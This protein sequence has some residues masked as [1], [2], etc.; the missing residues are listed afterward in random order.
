M[1][2]F[3]FLTILFLP[4]LFI[5][6]SEP[7]FWLFFV[8]GRGKWLHLVCVTLLLWTSDWRSE[9]KDWYCFCSPYGDWPGHLC[10]NGSSFAMQITHL[11]RV[12]N[13]QLSQLFLRTLGL[14]YS[15]SWQMPADVWWPSLFWWQHRLHENHIC[16]SDLG[17][18]FN[19]YLILANVFEADP[20][21]VWEQSTFSFSY[22]RS[23]FP[24]LR[25][26]YNNVNSKVLEVKEYCR[27]ALG[28]FSQQSLS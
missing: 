5:S 17:K 3:S 28:S 14:F 22:Y 19:E 2:Q 18:L 16:F 10:E 4:P 6:V 15:V 8:P 27:I 12:S 21:Q 26:K 20:L 9:F 23:I 7:I 25:V 1:L 13:H 24:C 11:L